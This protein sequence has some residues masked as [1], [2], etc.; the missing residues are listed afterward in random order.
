[1]R[2][3]LVVMAFLG[4]VYGTVGNFQSAASDRAASPLCV[5]AVPLGIVCCAAVGQALGGTTGRLMLAG[6]AGGG[7]LLLLFGFLRT[8]ERLSAQVPF[9]VLAV[10]VTVLAL[11]YFALKKKQHVAHPAEATLDQLKATKRSVRQAERSGEAL[12]PGSKPRRPQL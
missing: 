12:P 3:A 8:D 10:I 9:H 1:M 11:V 5:V 6:F 2:G 4:V 7:W